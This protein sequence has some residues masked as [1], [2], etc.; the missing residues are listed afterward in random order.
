MGTLLVWIGRLGGSV[1]V[2]LSAVA[3]FAR[4]RG[5]YN[6]AGFQVGTLLLGGIAAMVLGCLG[7]LAFMAERAGK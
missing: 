7:Y 6:V 3:V 4:Y 5:T 2:V 1:G